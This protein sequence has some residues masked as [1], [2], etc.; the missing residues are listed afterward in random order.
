MGASALNQHVLVL[1]AG[2]QPVNIVSAKRA[3]LLI[4]SG[5]AVA[6]EQSGQ[7]IRSARASW[8]LPRIIRLFIAIAHRVYRAVRVQL[9][10][11]NL[12]ARDRFACQ[13]CGTKQGPFT[14]DH[15]VP[16]SRRTSEFPSGGTTTWENCVTSCVRCNHRKGNQLLNE[17]GMHLIRQP[18]EPRWLPPLLFRRFLGDAVHKSWESYLYVN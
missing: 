10:R 12:F 16:R 3:L 18:E 1:D 8:E 13:Y 7:S 5:R 17:A 2:Y 15:V 11:K 4:Y 14:V 9:N 6:V